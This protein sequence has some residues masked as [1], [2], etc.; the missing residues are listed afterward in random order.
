MEIIKVA[1]GFVIAITIFFGGIFIACVGSN[2]S[3]T[4]STCQCVEMQK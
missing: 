3:E 2:N 1:I 4:E